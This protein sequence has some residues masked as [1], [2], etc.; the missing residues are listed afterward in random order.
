M[1]DGS[2]VE[3]RR[4]RTWEKD[5]TGDP[6]NAWRIVAKY[7]V[8]R[9]TSNSIM[10]ML[11]VLALVFSVV[12][13]GGLTFAAQEGFDYADARGESVYAGTP[14]E[15]LM[16]MQFLFLLP[17]G[18]FLLFVGAP[19]FS[20]DLRF[21]AP[22]LYF[23]KPLRT[24]QYLQ[25][26]LAHLAGTF[27]AF[28]LVPLSLFM[29]VVLT[30]GFPDPPAQYWYNDQP[31][32]A[33]QVAAW[34]SAHITGFAD[35]A[36]GAF[37]VILANINILAWTTAVT[38]LLSAYTQRAWH[39]A[40]GLVALVGAWGILGLVLM[41]SSNSVAGNL[42]GP[43]GWAYAIAVLPLQM[44]SGDLITFS[45]DAG[46]YDAAWPTVWGAH[47]LFAATTVLFL[48][49]IQRRLRRLEAIL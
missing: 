38:G 2:E 8:L 20:E 18:V 31:L 43:F 11:L 3:F 36:Y 14:W 19:M 27:A 26:K 7:A 34:R 16:G 46:Y 25:G 17:V 33:D 12:T 35:W 10:R 40:M 5:T 21:N 22:L 42:A 6:R 32:T 44:R 47:L 9:M 15:M 24:R 48:Y 23:S 45:D 1:S 37:F 4:F 13:V 29:L 30:M 28:S 41:D 49:L 39:A